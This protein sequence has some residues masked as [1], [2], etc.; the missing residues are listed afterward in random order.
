M[1]Q[2]PLYPCE[3]WHLAPDG[4]PGSWLQPGIAAIWGVSQNKEELSLML[5]LPLSFS[6]TPSVIAFQNLFKCF[7]KRTTANIY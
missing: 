5:S 2:V 3:C 1:I 7:Q 6:L 4:I